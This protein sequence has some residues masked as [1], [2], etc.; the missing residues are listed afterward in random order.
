MSR[1]ACDGG[2]NTR[3]LRLLSFSS[4]FPSATTTTTTKYKVMNSSPDG[5]GVVVMEETLDESIFDQSFD[6]H[7][8]GG[9]DDDFFDPLVTTK[10]DDGYWVSVEQVKEAAQ[11]S[12]DG[13]QATDWKN[14]NPEE[15]KYMSVTVDQARQQLFY[16]ARTEIDILE[17]AW[18]EKSPSFDKLAERIYGKRSK[19]YHK[20]LEEKVVTSY[21][22]FCRFLA[23]FHAACRRGMSVTQ[24]L[25]DADFKTK[26]LL[27]LKEFNYI[28]TIVQSIGVENNG[29]IKPVWMN[30]EEAYNDEVKDTFL[31]HRG[32]SHLSLALDDDKEKFNYS[33]NASTWGL[34]RCRHIQANRFGFTLHTCA[35]TAIGIVVCVMFQRESET[36]T[37]IYRR[38]IM[39]MFG[40]RCGGGNPNLHR[41]TF[42]SD[43]GYWTSFLVFCML[44]FWG[45]DVHGTVKRTHW[46]PFIYNK[47]P[48]GND[49]E[50][51][52]DRTKVSAKG[53]RD[54]F[55]KTYKYFNGAV[56]K[57]VRAIAYRSG[58]GNVSLA[59]TTIHNHIGIDFNTT[60]PKDVVWSFRTRHEESDEERNRRP[61]R[62]VC[63]SS[64]T[65]NLDVLM[66]N[67]NVHP[68]T[69]VQCDA[70]WFQMRKFSITSS[71][72]EKTI[73]E[74][75]REIKDDHPLREEYET[76]LHV[77]GRERWLSLPTEDSSD[78]DRTTAAATT[79]PSAADDDDDLP[80]NDNS[81]AY[82]LITNIDQQATRDDFLRD[83]E[84]DD[85]DDETIR[86][87]VGRH[88]HS[89]KTAAIGTLCKNLKAWAEQP[90]NLHRQYHWYSVA[91][92]KQ[93]LKEIDTRANT[94]G[95]KAVLLGVL[96]DCERKQ[97]D[98]NEA[99]EHGQV[100]CCC[101]CCCFC[102]SCL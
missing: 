11:G 43:R 46:F 13:P 63:G 73:E 96:V 58:T 78:D 26:G 59:M 67:Q 49:A 52:F 74:R 33:K 47:L 51:K 31:K 38:M 93:R 7:F 30:V 98:R 54:M 50:D 91:Q 97:T 62:L 92:L 101:C 37:Q 18:G 40:D 57:T 9:I 102:L 10:D 95:S 72:A 28:M 79:P 21:A 16:Q 84:D 94:T 41:M 87:I 4:F 12:T 76:V 5:D 61:F 27:P 34:Q 88:K 85:I 65:S 17:K 8:S 81:M 6:P 35:V 48:Q 20:L 53:Y 23:T 32:T 24:L 100:C 89:K 14:V 68:L 44:L 29:N 25:Q 83:L 19:L 22:M 71:T 70:P 45:A 55:Y 64:D 66:N 1:N 36:Q 69:T 3:L 56:R 39:F 86:D 99:R 60:F 80:A 42:C 77:V 15:M 90:S 75:S 82:Y 2:R